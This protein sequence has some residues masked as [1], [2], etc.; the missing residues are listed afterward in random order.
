MYVYSSQR[1]PFPISIFNIFLIICFKYRLITSY[2]FWMYTLADPGTSFSVNFTH[3]PWL[4]WSLIDLTNTNMLLYRS[5]VS[6]MERLCISKCPDSSIFFT[7]SW[8]SALGICCCQ[9]W[10]VYLTFQYH[11]MLTSTD[12]IITKKLVHFSIW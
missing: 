2:S 12:W 7:Y 3:I 1:L 9:C 4:F 6:T 11:A 5:Y 10:F 8:K